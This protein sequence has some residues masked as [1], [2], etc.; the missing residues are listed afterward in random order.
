MSSIAAGCT[1]TVCRD[2]CCGSARKHPRVD[3][4]AQ[5]DPLP[6]GVD[7]RPVTELLRPAY[8]A[9]GA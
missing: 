4:D 6:L 5:L 3:H 8:Q 9:M 2:C 1:V 7:G